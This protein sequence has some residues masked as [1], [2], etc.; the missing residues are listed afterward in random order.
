MDEDKDVPV[1]LGRPFLRTARTV[2]DTYEGTLTMRIGGE[3][4]QFQV[5]KTEKYPD[6][7]DDCYRIDA[8]DELNEP[9]NQEEAHAARKDPHATRNHSTLAPRKDYHAA[10]KD[11]D[12]LSSD[13]AVCA[14]E[15]STDEPERMP[16]ESHEVLAD[17]TPPL[18]DA[19]KPELKPL[20][21]NL[22][23]EFLDFDRSSPEIEGT[24]LSPDETSRLL[25][26][27][28]IHEGAI[29]YSIEE[30]KGLN[31]A[32]CAHCI[33]LEESRKPSVQHRR[34]LNPTLQ[35]N[36]KSKKK[37]RI[38]GR[39]HKDS[40]DCTL[41]AASKTGLAHRMTTFLA[42]RKWSHAACKGLQNL[43]QK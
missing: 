35:G 23:Y 30:L 10:R 6:S 5:D 19:S 16:C 29:R 26:K 18:T 31:P 13:E 14:A 15:I 1:I 40:R 12:K 11:P 7:P 8:N 2:F 25:E 27:L 39:V 3:K 22:R 24:D 17:R 33:H 9:G 37:V 43:I 32:I 42:S 41:L 21:A 28:R 34:Q 36:V 38:R 20:P 4:V